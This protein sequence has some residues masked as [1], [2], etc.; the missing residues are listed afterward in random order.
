MRGLPSGQDY[1]QDK[2]AFRTGLFFKARLYW[3]NKLHS[4]QDGIQ[5]RAVFG[6]ELYSWEGHIQG[7]AEFKA[8]QYSG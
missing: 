8:G 2:T 6:V 5:G 7:R 4:G 1:I 3:N